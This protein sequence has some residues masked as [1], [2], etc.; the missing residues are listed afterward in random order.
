MKFRRRTTHRDAR[1]H[2][3]THK[4]TKTRTDAENDS[5]E[6]PESTERL[7]T[8]KKTKHIPENPTRAPKDAWR[9]RGAKHVPEGPKQI[10]RD[11][12]H[13]G[14]PNE[15]LEIAHKPGTI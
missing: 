14:G 11:L 3:K 12:E 15:P 8:L 9:P 1:R 10:L 6:V 5:K 13:L 7:R 4:D 2:T